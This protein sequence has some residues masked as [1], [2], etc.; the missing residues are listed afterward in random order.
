MGLEVWAQAHGLTHERG[1][2]GLGPW[3]QHLVCLPR[4]GARLAMLQALA[5]SRGGY[6]VVI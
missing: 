2:I 6:G 5:T 3:A 1:A 4:T